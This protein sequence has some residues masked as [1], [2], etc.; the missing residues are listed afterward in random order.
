MAAA[1][2]SAT[3][4]I[5]TARGNNL[6]LQKSRTRYNLRKFVFTNTVVNMWNGLPNGVVHAEYNSVF[7]TRLDKFWSNQE[8]YY[9]YHAKLKG[10]GNRSV[11]VINWKLF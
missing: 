10:R 2:N 1:S 11:H 6:R 8:I 9:D 7:K 3:V 4:T 5:F